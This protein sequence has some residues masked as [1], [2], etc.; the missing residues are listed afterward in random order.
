MRATYVDH[1]LTYVNTQTL[2]PMKVV[3]NAGNGGAGAVVDA[4]Q[5]HLPFEFIKIH[6]TPDGNFPNGIPNPL[7]PENQGVTAKA[8]FEH[9]AAV[10]IAWDG[11]FDRCFSSMKR[12]FC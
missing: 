2:Q 5:A 7:L 10:G 12:Q 6:H 9:G 11:D 8:V 4:L 1:L 3:V